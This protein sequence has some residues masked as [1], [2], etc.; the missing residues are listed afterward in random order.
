MENKMALLD[1]TILKVDNPWSFWLKEAPSPMM[2]IET[3]MFLELNEKIQDYCSGQLHIRKYLLQPKKGQVCLAKRSND[4]RWY[5]AKILSIRQSTQGPQASLHLLDFAEN[6]RSPVSW[7][8]EVPSEF[9]Q[10]PF[11]VKEAR[12]YN[13]QPITLQTCVIDL[14]VSPVPCMVWDTSAVDYFKTTVK[15][16]TS[17]KV[18]VHHH[19]N[20]AN[21]FYVTLYLN[22][23]LEGLVDIN[24]Y[25]ITKN[26]AIANEIGLSPSK[27]DDIRQVVDVDEY[28]QIQLKKY[29]MAEKQAQEDTAKCNTSDST[30]EMAVVKTSSEH[31]LSV[32][33]LEK[34]RSVNKEGIK[35]N[36]PLQQSWGFPDD[37][38]SK[39]SEDHWSDGTPE[40]RKKYNI[41]RGK[42]IEDML[43]G[44]DG[45]KARARGIKS[46]ELQPVMISRR[47]QKPVESS[48][49]D[50][51][52]LSESSSFG[53]HSTLWSRQFTRDSETS[54]DSSLLFQ[55]SQ[56]NKQRTPVFAEESCAKVVLKKFDSENFTNKT[57]L[58]SPEERPRKSM[59]MMLKAVVSSSSIDSDS[60]AVTSHVRSKK[61]KRH[62]I[63]DLL[64]GSDESLQH[65]GDTFLETS[66]ESPSALH[67]FAA[68]SKFLEPSSD[69]LQ[70]ESSMTKSPDSHSQCMDGDLPRQKSGLSMNSKMS[71][72]SSVGLEDPRSL[73]NT[74]PDGKMNQSLD[75]SFEH[76]KRVHWK[77]ELEAEEKQMSTMPHSLVSILKT[78]SPEPRYSG[79]LDERFKNS[80]SE[81]SP[82]KS[83]TESDK[84]LIQ[85]RLT[86]QLLGDVVPKE[87][88]QLIEDITLVHGDRPL[89]PIVELSQAPFPDMFK[90]MLKKKNLYSPTLIE[91]HG[92]PTILRGR[93]M[94]GVSKESRNLAYL[95]PLFT[96]VVQTSAY[97]A[98]PKGNG[99][100]IIVIVPRWKKAKEVYDD[101]LSMLPSSRYIRAL[102]IHGAGAEE[103]KEIDL[104]NGC[105]I[106]IATPL[107][108]LRL[109]KKSHLNTDR[110]C[111]LVFDDAD[112]VFSDFTQEVREIM[113]AYGKTLLEKPNRSA[114]R[115]I[116]AF[117][118]H[119]TAGLES[120]MKAYQ[121]DPLVV[122][123]RKL[124]AAVYGKVWHIVHSCPSNYKFNKVLDLLDTSHTQVEGRRIVIFTQNKDDALNL[125]HMLLNS[126]HYAL[127]V[128]NDMNADEVALVNHEWRANHKQ[129]SMPVLVMTD[130]VDFVL[131]NAT[132][133]IHFD[134]PSSRVMFGDRLSFCRE[135]F[136]NQLEQNDSKNTNKSQCLSHMLI[137][138]EDF[139]HL[140]GFA[141]FLK[142]TRQKLPSKFDLEKAKLAKEEKKKTKKLCKKLKTYG[143][144]KDDHCHFR[145]KLY[146]ELDSPVMLNKDTSIADSRYV[147]VLICYIMDATHY[148]ARIVSTQNDL[149]GEEHLLD[150]GT[151]IKLNSDLQ[152]WFEDPRRR[153]THSD[154]K[155]GDLCVI[156]DSR[157]MFHRARVEMLFSSEHGTKQN[158]TVQLVD[159]G[160]FEVVTVNKLLNLP[161]HL[162]HIPFQVVEV[163]LCHLKP[164]DKDTDWTNQ[165]S[166]F[167]HNL[168]YQKELCGKVVLSLGNTLW[169]D[170]LVERVQ[171]STIKTVVNE[172]NIR[173][174]LLRA[175][176]AEHN[177]EHI[178]LLK[179][180]CQGKIDI[181]SPTATEKDEE[182]EAQQLVTQSMQLSIRGVNEVYLSAMDTPDLIYV[183]R[184][185]KFKRLEALMKEI[186]KR[187]EK[188]LDNSVEKVPVDGGG[189]CSEDGSATEGGMTDKS[190]A[191]VRQWNPGSYC[192][193]KLLLDETW[194]RG[195][196]VEQVKS[197]KLVYTVFFLDYG[198]LED[199]AGEDIYPIWDDALQLPFQAIECRLYG[200]LPTDETWN[201][202]VG[203]TMWDI[204][205]E[206]EGKRILDATVKSKELSDSLTAVEY[207]NIELR[208]NAATPSSLSCTSCDLS[209]NLVLQGLALPSEDTVQRMFPTSQDIESVS[210]KCK[211]YY[212][213]KDDDVKLQ[214][215]KDISNIT[216][217]I[218]KSDVGLEPQHV[219]S[220]CYIFS[221]STN[222]NERLLL[223]QSI[224]R[225]SYRNFRNCDVIIEHGCIK[226]VC[227]LLKK[228]DDC[229]VIEQVLC[230]LKIVSITKRVRDNLNELDVD[231]ICGLL[232]SNNPSIVSNCCLVLRKLMAEHPENQE[233]LKQ[234]GGLKMLCDL[235]KLQRRNVDTCQSILGVLVECASNSR[236]RDNIR[237]LGGLDELCDIMWNVENEELLCLSAQTLKFL[238]N[239][240]TANLTAMINEGMQDSIESLLM[241]PSYS[242]VTVHTLS[243]LDIQLLEFS[244]MNKAKLELVKRAEVEGVDI[245]ALQTIEPQSKP[246]AIADNIPKIAPKKKI[247]QNIIVKSKLVSRSKDMSEMYPGYK[248]AMSPIYTP[249]SCDV[250]EV[251]LSDLPPLIIADTTTRT[252]PKVLWSQKPNLILL[253]VQLRGV[254]EHDTNVTSQTVSFSTIL[255]IVCYEFSLDLFGSVSTTNHVVLVTG[256]EVL[257]TLFKQNLVCWPRLTKSK[258]KVSFIGVDFER[259]QDN[260]SSSDGVKKEKS[261]KP[262]VSPKSKENKTISSQPQTVVLPEF[263]SSSGKTDET[264]SNSEDF[265]F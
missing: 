259:W 123:T 107:C 143:T 24:E 170:P 104:I 217:N 18:K 140:T 119:W 200:V 103:N 204:C 220:L 229:D 260:S 115:Q 39:S 216:S 240:N 90:R 45:S 139:E 156:E 113:Q 133:V 264:S 50:S 161:A 116:L 172:H 91:S 199:I 208:F 38:I 44:F 65:E 4:K 49:A 145:H 206:N 72:E 86:R 231:S 130:E 126:S 3:E 253:S 102:I 12:L 9:L 127:V 221:V 222:P 219:R 60:T 245:H 101:A 76:S 189:D 13:T 164:K 19:D 105:E 243:D 250:E 235:L 124:E 234:A 262:T 36:K 43:S 99:P 57:K 73:V 55:P 64:E 239:G 193:A 179:E 186:N 218:I 74:S 134:F 63:L 166:A 165:A 257:I 247:E 169:L 114:P 79:G 118:A 190:K 128:H 125:H 131:T 121:S 242:E 61:K 236:Y 155:C 48:S 211:E 147:K 47:K 214:L 144:C 34:L 171:L 228:S 197:E 10:V 168:I 31:S 159:N 92:W 261:V 6:I 173:L 1:V 137:G 2:S 59:V 152:S 42:V 175:G 80:D 252:H 100:L 26:Y 97:S 160:R 54:N 265:N 110:L 215:V 163:F 158:A 246:L 122:L 20:S 135:N 21:V 255:D 14:T 149:S 237:E 111:H 56:K 205:N 84:K 98:L 15:D 53:A 35:Q 32:K 66:S 16:A 176:F 180:R 185:D 254:Q 263:D 212:Q 177:T 109:L 58:K 162:Y 153:V 157:Y 96:Q 138:P 28:L 195:K 244:F 106:L 184:I 230:I 183:Q 8:R 167:V 258:T 146:A 178:K 142:R 233:L 108:F 29:E 95:L 148:F 83:S 238:G 46:D 225:T 69:R 224:V 75:S 256:G 188:S 94:V 17:S 112:V 85:E 232:A 93:D 182:K 227:S 129:D 198:D 141:Q 192:L 151:T 194:Y 154:A 5:R 202:D 7:L 77:P 71:Q 241:S 25:L 249:N 187:M 174:E 51:L 87:N 207:Y 248:A 82:R 223:L 78:P 88:V 117:S 67:N 203:N 196:I 11:Q 213:A 181:C 132:W 68:N 40:R 136:V 62:N 70:R 30:T 226:E 150:S 209:V 89:R 201:Q 191:S 120:F 52:G 210:G 22:R 23:P 41:G 27:S 251:D 37:E 81:T 33:Q